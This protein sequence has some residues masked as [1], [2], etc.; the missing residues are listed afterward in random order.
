MN[1][2]R[3]N[4]NQY[5]TM[6]NVSEHID[7][8]KMMDLAL[9][10]AA[11]ADPSA[12]I[13]ELAKMGHELIGK[14]IDAQNTRSSEIFEL[15][16]ERLETH[17]AN[18]HWRKIFGFAFRDE[19]YQTAFNK[20][21]FELRQMLYENQMHQDMLFAKALEA[22]KQILCESL[23]AAHAI[24]GTESNSKLPLLPPGLN[25]G[26]MEDV[27]KRSDVQSGGQYERR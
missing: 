20:A 7:H 14:V 1:L 17:Y 23:E 8:A 10:Q 9:K 25:E 27:V 24:S 5:N 12:L 19:L 21:F 11:K 26:G 3:H 15:F 22:H 16:R 13:T 6:R 18:L 4:L 2:Q